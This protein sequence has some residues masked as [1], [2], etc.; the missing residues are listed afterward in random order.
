[1]S[2]FS[3]FTKLV[4]ALVAVVILFVGFGVYLTASRSS[5]PV[6][7]VPET[8]VEETESQVVDNVSFTQADGLEKV[9]EVPL[10]YASPVLAVGNRVAYQ[11]R[12]LTTYVGTSRLDSVLPAAP[13]EWFYTA[14]GEFLVDSE[15]LPFV[16]EN[17]NQIRYFPDGITSITR[18][19]DG[20][21]YLA[22]TDDP[23]RFEI[24][25]TPDLFPA[26]D[27]P[28]LG[29]V[30]AAFEFPTAKIYTIAETT[31][32]L[33]ENRASTEYELWQLLD[34]RVRK[35]RE[36]S[37]V[38]DLKVFADFLLYTDELEIP[39]DLTD[40]R[41]NFLDL[42]DPARPTLQDLNWTAAL[43]QSGV[44]GQPLPRRCASDEN[45]KLYCLAKAQDVS[46]LQ[47]EY[48]DVLFT[49]DFETQRIEYPYA[50]LTFSASRVYVVGGEVY[51]NI[52]GEEAG[53]LYKF[54]R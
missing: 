5:E 42:R 49:Y 19:Q 26:P 54:G 31:Y 22:S 16:V 2:R 47:D 51:L 9:S 30:Q 23:A 7:P 38:R 27:V 36:L 25:A 37:G 12:D 18:Y 28:A 50:A 32:V 46:S 15:I 35:V 44:Y 52:T 34:G 1:M 13:R 3:S 24:K 53:G 14:Q 29:T 10:A 6:T 17:T 11:D 20:Y 8:L 43:G 21:R 39:N 4:I 48:R 40:V 33:F 41:L 45:N